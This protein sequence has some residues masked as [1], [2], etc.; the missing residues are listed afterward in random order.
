[1]EDVFNTSSGRD[2]GQSTPAIL[3]GTESPKMYQNGASRR[4]MLATLPFMA[5]NGPYE[6]GRISHEISI[7]QL[8]QKPVELLF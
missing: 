8:P 3:H 2:Y 1:M 6:V 5:T 4:V 7:C